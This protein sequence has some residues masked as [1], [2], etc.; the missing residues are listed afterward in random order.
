MDDFK[1][2]SQIRSQP[3]E[4]AR[5]LSDKHAQDAAAAAA[6]VFSVA[7]RVD[8]VGIGTSHNAAL[9]AAYLLRAAGI[10][11]IAWSSYDYTLYGAGTDSAG[12]KPLLL[13]SVSRPML[14][15]ELIP[16]GLLRNNP[17]KPLSRLR[18]ANLAVDLWMTAYWW[19]TI[20]QAGIQ[21]P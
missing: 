1:L 16:R 21:G 14:R 8:I 9:T 13:L 17:S 19:Q 20:F 6:R 3:A 4:I 7:G 10:D 11:A 12:G 2:A 15:A 18:S 5:L